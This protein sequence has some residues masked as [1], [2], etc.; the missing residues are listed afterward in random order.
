MRDEEGSLWNCS[1]KKSFYSSESYVMQTHCLMEM[2]YINGKPAIWYLYL[3]LLELLRKN[4]NIVAVLCV[5]VNYCPFGR[6][7]YASLNNFF[8]D[9]YA[10]GL[11]FLWN[12][13]VKWS[14]FNW[15]DTQGDQNSLVSLHWWVVL[16]THM[17]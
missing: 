1:V 14:R 17:T 9:T 5:H 8:A 2:F 12:A 4:R 7:Q 6:H 11:M 13:L 3:N 16:W 15:G 10:Q